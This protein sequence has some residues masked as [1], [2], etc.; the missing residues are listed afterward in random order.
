M[1][2]L[3]AP[4]QNWARVLPVSLAYHSLIPPTL[5]FRQLSI[6]SYAAD[7][8]E[9][10]SSSLCRGLH[11]LL[12]FIWEGAEAAAALRSLPMLELGP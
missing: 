6:Q 11:V 9:A 1:P 7:H 10:G 8:L 12:V 4:T 5:P 3:R 2:E